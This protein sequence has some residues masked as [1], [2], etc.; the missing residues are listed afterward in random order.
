MRI[1]ATG[2]DYFL[3]GTCADDADLDG[4]FTMVTDDGE[5]LRVH[6]WMFIIDVIPDPQDGPP[7]GGL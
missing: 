6:G 4:T 5:R 7:D 3:E 2:G 1:E